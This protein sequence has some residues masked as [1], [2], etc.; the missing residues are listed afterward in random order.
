MRL[1]AASFNKPNKLA[2]LLADLGTGE[3]GFGGTPV[4]TGELSLDEYLQYCIDRTD[5]TKLRPG[6]VPQTVFWVIDHQEEATGIVRM[7]HYLNDK[8]REHSGHIGFYIRRDQRGKG[9]G[10]E[11]LRLALEELKKIGETKA[12]LTVDTD[13]FASIRVILANGGIFDSVGQDAEGTKFE[14]YWIDMS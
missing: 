1:E 9:Y 4:A 2:E 11:T 14:R 5:T 10:K 12:L 8:L 6:Y 13:N 7:R 3:N